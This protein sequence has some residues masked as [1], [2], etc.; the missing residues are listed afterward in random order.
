MPDHAYFI[1]TGRAACLQ[2][3][4]LVDALRT[5]AIRGA[6]MDVYHREPIAEDDPLLQMDNVVTTPHIAA[7]SQDVIDRHSSLT[8]D[9]IEAF[10]AGQEPMHVANPETLDPATE[11][12]QRDT[13]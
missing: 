11:D 7:A 10:L 4:A 6:A 2:E 13:R 9:D 12:H 3:G 8:V 5:E 1:N